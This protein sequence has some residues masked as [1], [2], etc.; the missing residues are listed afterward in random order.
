MPSESYAEFVNNTRA[1]NR[2]SHFNVTRVRIND[3]TLARQPDENGDYA[4][5]AEC[6]P[7]IHLASAADGFYSAECCN[8]YIY[9][10]LSVC[11]FVCL[12]YLL[13]EPMRQ[14]GSQSAAWLH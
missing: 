5:W 13:V 4:L 8:V 7:F 14:F 3:L 6:S 2:A 11:W 12:R 1:E 10:G 9:I